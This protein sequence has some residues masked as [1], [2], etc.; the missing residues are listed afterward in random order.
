[1]AQRRW[2]RS[3]PF[4]PP[5]MLSLR[6]TSHPTPRCRRGT[7]SSACPPRLARPPMVR[8]QHCQESGRCC[9]RRSS[10]I[11]R[12]S[13]GTSTLQSWTLPCSCGCLA[14]PLPTS[15][16]SG[17]SGRPC[18]PAATRA[19]LRTCSC[20]IPRSPCASI[21]TSSRRE[22]VAGSPSTPCWCTRDPLIL[23]LLKLVCQSWSI[24]RCTS[25]RSTS[26]SPTKAFSRRRWWSTIPPP[27][28]PS[29]A[30][31]SISTWGIKPTR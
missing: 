20:G 12:K 31:S 9:T 17:T 27:M 6:R 13:S 14:E 4:R 24:D 26:K 18:Q 11:T 8:K 23:I 25:R 21:A 10:S 7:I 29:P 3:L 19:S 30:S 16:T 1:M 28:C 22:R 15:V 5:S 2:S